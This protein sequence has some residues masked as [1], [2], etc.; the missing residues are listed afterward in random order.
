MN[1]EKYV[2]IS[3]EVKEAIKEKKPVVALESTIISHGMPYPKNVET[4][5]EVEKV[6]RENGAIPATIAI[7]NGE[8]KIGL[9]KEE[10]E[11]IGKAGL[12][13]TKTSRR[14]LAYVVANKLNGAT[15]V[16][17][18]M[19]CAQMANIKIFATGGIG[20]VH[21]GAEKTMDISADLEELGKT[22]VAVICAGCKSILD[23][24]LTLEYLETKGVAV[25]GYKTNILPAFYT[26]ES[27][28]KVNKINSEQEVAKVLKAKWDLGLDGGVVITNPIPE[29]FSMDRKII[30][31]TILEALKEA[32][33]KGIKGKDITPFLLD[34]I[35]K[36]TSGKSLEANIEL[37]F[38]NAKLASKIAIEYSKLD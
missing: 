2:K 30:D 15:T 5:L 25:Y 11:I 17:A 16:A 28:F 14:D 27:D 35:Q 1:L 26:R 36:L 10:I 18:T 38:N 19:I 12:S 24:G 9:T 29:E 3:Q 33:E 6:V 7:I 34:K 13:V 37:V 22:N 31:K 21:R 4:A 20:G 23:M 8:I 32:D